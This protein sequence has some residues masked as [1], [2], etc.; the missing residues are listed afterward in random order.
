MFIFHILFHYAISAM[1]LSEK[2]IQDKEQSKLIINKLFTILSCF[3][4]NKLSGRNEKMDSR[5]QSEKKAEQFKICF[6]KQ[7]MKQQKVKRFKTLEE[8]KRFKQTMR[9]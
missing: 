5:L 4:R 2:L 9:S 7:I 3:Q 1:G 8:V 6:R